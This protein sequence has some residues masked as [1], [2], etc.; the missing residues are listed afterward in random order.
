MNNKILSSL[1]LSVSIVISPNIFAAEMPNKDIAVFALANTEE[2]V[3]VFTKPFHLTFRKGYDNQPKFSEDGKKIFFTRAIEQQTDIMEYSFVTKQLVNLTN[4][5]KLSEYSP[6]PYQ[7]GY[8]SAI[9]QTAEGKQYLNKVSLKSGGSEPFTTAIEPIG[10]HAWL[11]SEQAPV[12]VLGD[13]MTL[14]VLHTAENRKPM[15]L[16]ENIGRCFERVAENKVS[17]TVEIEGLHQIKFIDQNHDLS[18]SGI[19][20]PE[21]VQDYVW[22]DS[23]S[24]I[25]GLESK[26]YKMNK[27]SSQEI[28][29]LSGAGIRKISR[30]AYSKEVEKLAV[31]Y[32]R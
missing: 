12:F 18:D 2:G 1:L 11:N 10:Y 16:A 8:L 5:K 21:G 17:F 9:G 28:A 27:E 31:V 14:Q 23:D 30:L 29:D 24:I 7:P 25:F 32:E 4:T 26:L 13:V 6:T 20:L 15:I 22:L 3:D 19:V